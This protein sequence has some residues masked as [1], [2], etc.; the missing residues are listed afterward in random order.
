MTDIVDINFAMSSYDHVEIL[1]SIKT[2]GAKVAL[3][4]KLRSR[5]LENEDRKRYEAVLAV[6][7]K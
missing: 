3:Y 5:A 1:K 7:K 6:Y 4:E 2:L